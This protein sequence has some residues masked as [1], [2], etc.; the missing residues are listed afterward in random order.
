MEDLF[1]I[2]GKITSTALALAG[3]WWAFEKWRK[4]DELFPRVYFEVSVNFIGAKDEHI[5]CELVS[6]LENKGEVPVKIRDF[7]FVLRGL[8]KTA[9]LGRG[10]PNI[11]NQLNFPDTLDEGRFIPESWD[12]SF[13]YPGVKTEYNFVTAIPQHISF[14]RMQGDFVYLLDG[15]DGYTHHAAKILK[16]PDFRPTTTPPP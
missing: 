5:I 13:I 3:G 11:R 4:K 1:S 2:I 10:G 6:T 14:V 8:A 9:P 12:S 7:T 15:K 16:V